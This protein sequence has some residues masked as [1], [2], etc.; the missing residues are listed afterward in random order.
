MSF[1]LDICY[2]RTATKRF[3]WAMCG[4]EIIENLL[5]KN[6]RLISYPF[7][8]ENGDFDYCGK[9]FS[10]RTISLEDTDENNS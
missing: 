9:K 3:A 1:V 5:E 2:K 10:I 4:D 6:N 8:D 7:Y